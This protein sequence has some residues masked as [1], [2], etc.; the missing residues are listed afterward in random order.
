[1]KWRMDGHVTLCWSSLYHDQR[2]I[3]GFRPL[4]Y[5]EVNRRDDMKSITRKRMEELEKAGH[6]VN[7]YPR[8][9]QVCV[10]GFKYYRV[11]PSTKR[12]RRCN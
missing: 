6:A 1:M 10:D 3:G 9:K 4:L 11:V 2:T 5:Y 12:I 8:L 7:E